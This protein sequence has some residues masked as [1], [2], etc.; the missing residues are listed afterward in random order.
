MMYGLINTKTER[1]RD[2]FKA[3]LEKIIELS[4]YTASKPSFSHHE[5]IIVDVFNIADKA[6]KG[7]EKK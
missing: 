5:R 1:E 4:E 6:I 7:D 3:A 2:R